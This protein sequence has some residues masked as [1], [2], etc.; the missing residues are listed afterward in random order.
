MK[1]LLHLTAPVSSF[2]EADN[3]RGEPRWERNVLG[4]L[5]A[6]GRETHTTKKVW[7]SPQPPPTNLYDGINEAWLDDSILITHGI[8]RNPHI[9]SRARHYL[10]QY[11]EAPPKEL[12]HLFLDFDL[13]Q[14]G[15]IIATTSER[16]PWVLD[17]LCSALGKEKVEWLEGPNVRDVLSTDN[18]RAKYF[19]WI[20]RNFM[21]CVEEQ[22]QE[23]AELFQQV[24]GYLQQEP[25]T[26][27]GI[28]IGAW[29]S[30]LGTP[31]HKGKAREWAFSHPA[32]ETLRGIED[33]VD[34]FINLHQHEVLHL[35]SETR[36]IISPAE[37]AGLPLYEAAR[38]GIPTILG[39]A[40]NPLQG[41]DGA[42]FPELLT[43]PSRR[44][45][46]QFL[47]TIEQ[48]QQDL[49][50][51]RKHGEAYRKYVQGAATYKAFIE[52]L[53]QIINKRGWA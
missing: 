22:G 45:S 1:F 51:Y 53:D 23:V 6:A 26:R 4:A 47:R 10:V 24:R 16:N 38:Y 14:P 5:L 41:K 18:S 32:L 2:I 3:L 13:K 36:I 44:I 12:A 11:H 27:I 8:A 42:C 49:S 30:E 40:T 39:D 7:F 20:Y 46:G 28:L 31:P 37:P 19:S 9:T 21:S 34:I 35:L 43:A 50:F 29:P 17:R 33:R 52:H 15:S 25:G 48:L